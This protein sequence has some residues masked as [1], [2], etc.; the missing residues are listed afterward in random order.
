MPYFIEMSFQSLG[1]E[2]MSILQTSLRVFRFLC[3]MDYNNDKFICAPTYSSNEVMW[4]LELVGVV[5]CEYYSKC[6]VQ[7]H[8]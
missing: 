2:K 6:C 3:N 7:T 5:E 1:R 4:L 8:V